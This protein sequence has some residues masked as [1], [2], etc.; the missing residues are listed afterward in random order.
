M[1][2]AP[3]ALL[4]E[5]GAF[6]EMATGLSFASGRQHDLRRIVED[7]AQQEGFSSVEACLHGMMAAAP[8]R[9][10]VQ[11]LGRYF[12]NRETYFFRDAA[13]FS[14]LKLEIL[15]RLIAARRA[16]GSKAL[17]LL[18]A[19]C[20][21]GEEAYSLAML[22]R[23]LPGMGEWDVRVV[24]VDMNPVLLQTARA[25]SYGA[26]SFRGVPESLRLRH[27]EPL[28]EERFALLP[29]IKAGVEFRYLNLAGADFSALD[30]ATPFDLV[31]CQNVL[32]YFGVEAW[33]NTVAKIHTVLADDACLCV[34]PVECERALYPQYRPAEFDG[35]TFFYKA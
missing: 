13:M 29:R 26:W 10:A 21:S 17:R 2:P 9:A 8:D 24:G 27:F 35:L 19:G 1:I 6:V 4:E 3:Q 33:R 30:D 23:D 34:A 18:S 7:M 31:L 32:M 15:P 25:A 16:K 20:S 28:G 22:A 12:S 5:F 11:K 14:V